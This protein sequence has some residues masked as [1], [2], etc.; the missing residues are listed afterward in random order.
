MGLESWLFETG[1]E[2]HDA[3]WL[4]SQ[5]NLGWSTHSSMRLDASAVGATSQEDK[6]LMLG[7]TSP[8]RTIGVRLYQSHISSVPWPWNGW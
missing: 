1:L 7:L 6:L 8:S 4:R 5:S 2:D 3:S